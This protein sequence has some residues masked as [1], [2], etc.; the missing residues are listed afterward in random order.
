MKNTSIIIIL[1]II[2]ICISCRKEVQQGQ[3][4]KANGFVIDSIKNKKLPNVKMYLFGGKQ[5]FYGVYYT[6]GPLDST[7]SDNNGNF[8]IKYAAEGKSID[9]ALMIGKLGYGG[10]SYQGN[11]NYVVDVTHS[12][13]PF[14]YTY[15]LKDVAIKARELNYT[16][17]A[18]R[19]LYNP[20]DTFY[21]RI[22]PPYGQFYLSYLIKGQNIDTV[23]YTRTLPNFQNNI[24]YCAEKNR[25]DSG[26]VSR[27][28]TD[29]L[30]TNLQDTLSVTK[31]I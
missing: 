31:T 26:S 13:Y 12:V 5:T 16:K 30:N 4:I 8:S 3:I 21:I 29:T 14:N 18:L 6:I 2:F 25:P 19:V 23:I 17:I 20:Y 10:Y 24:S 22:F 1:L 27:K 11:I 28:I 7:V 15:E 9:Y